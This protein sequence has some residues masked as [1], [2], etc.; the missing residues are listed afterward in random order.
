MVLGGGLALVCRVGARLCAF[1]LAQVIETLR[2]LPFE[3][4]TSVPSFVLGLS[5]IRGL[6]VPVV[7][8]ARVLTGRS[9]PI[10]RIA[11]LRVGT[12]RVA[13]GVSAVLGVEALAEIERLPP[14]LQSADTE[15][16][17]AI[18]LLDSDFITVLNGCRIL[19]DD[20]LDQVSRQAM[21]S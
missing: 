17:A 1:P 19:P 9:A 7:D 20:V 14:L 21:A 16:I 6:P 4:I 2:P 13:L 18:G 12:R 10:N 5:L 8:L 11:L 15:I 3:P